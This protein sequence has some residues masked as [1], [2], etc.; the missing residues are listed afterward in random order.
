MYQINP[1]IADTFKIRS[2]AVSEIMAGSML[3]NGLTPNQKVELDELLI[4]QASGLKGLT[5][6][7]TE[8]LSELTMRFNA[9][10]EL[11]AGAKTYCQKWLKQ[12]S[13]M[14][15]RKPD[16]Q[17]KYT[18]KGLIVEDHAIDFIADFFGFGFL[19]KNEERRSNDFM[20][21]EPDVIIPPKSLIIDNKSSW[22][23]ETFP[24]FESKI[25]DMGYWWQAQSYMELF[26]MENFWLVY[27]LMDTPVNI[28]ERECKSFSYRNGLG[29]VTQEMMMEFV[30]K[31]T[32]KDVPDELKI[33]VFKFQRD[34]SVVPKIEQRVKMCREYIRQ[35]IIDK[36][37]NIEY[38]R[39]AA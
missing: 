2:S 20:S 34:R 15:N 30:A 25:P 32:Y 26:N 11:P 13:A 35:L 19:M 27:T 3:E 9:K 16:N 7:Q 31:M 5:V 18:E 17:T 37:K 38:L 29:E 12:S 36:N 39:S 28:I 23:C 4:K 14:Y 8:R 22:D 1:E 21:G 24:T 6:K 10:P 33:M